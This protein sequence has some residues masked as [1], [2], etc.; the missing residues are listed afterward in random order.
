MELQNAVSD[1][2]TVDISSQKYAVS[3]LVIH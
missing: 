1:A 2:T 3:T